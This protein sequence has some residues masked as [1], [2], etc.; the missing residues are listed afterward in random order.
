[1][2]MP[3][4]GWRA[5]SGP[6]LPASIRAT[7]VGDKRWTVLGVLVRFPISAVSA[8]SIH[9]LAPVRR[10]AL[11]RYGGG[12]SQHRSAP[13]CGASTGSNAECGIGLSSAALDSDRGT[14]M[15]AAA[16]G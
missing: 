14:A 12:D 1:M 13:T 7:V 16:D 9:S 11:S 3:E 15:T 2:T 4:D 8:K 10:A 5:A 6:C